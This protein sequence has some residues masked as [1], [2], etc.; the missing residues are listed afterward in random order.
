[1]RTALSRTCG[2][3][4]GRTWRAMADCTTTVD[5]LPQSE[6]AVQGAAGQSVEPAK[7]ASPGTP[8]HRTRG[9]QR[10]RSRAARRTQ[11]PEGFRCQDRSPP[12][13]RRAGRRYDPKRALSPLHRVRDFDRVTRPLV[14]FALEQRRHGGPGLSSRRESPGCLAAHHR[15]ASLRRLR[16]SP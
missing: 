2:A 9:P 3:G 6:S 16:R 15:A 11:S 10:A 14:E 12:S 7:G 4:G 8:R 1:L 13:Q 5:A